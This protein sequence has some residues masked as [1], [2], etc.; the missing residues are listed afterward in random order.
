V[1]GVRD[2]EFTSGSPFAG[3][4]VLSLRYPLSHKRE[5][6]NAFL[7]PPMSEIRYRVPV[8]ARGPGVMGLS[9]AEYKSM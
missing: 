3:G 7:V 5:R 6:A 8:G 9:I 2:L 1:G 4:R